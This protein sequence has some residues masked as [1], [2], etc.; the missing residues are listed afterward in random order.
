[1]AESNAIPVLAHF[2]FTG[3][4]LIAF[5]GVIGISVPCETDFKGGAPRT[6]LRL[7]ETSSAKDIEFKTESGNMSIKAGKSKFNVAVL[8]FEDFA[9]QMD[10]IPKLPKELYDIDADKFIEALGMCLRSVGNNN[11]RADMMGVTIIR[12]KGDLFFFSYDRVSVSQASMRG[13]IDAK[14]IIVPAE[15]CK[16]AIAL[17]GKDGEFDVD[18][19]EDACLIAANGVKLWAAPLAPDDVPQKFF[20]IVDSQM[21]KAG[22]KLRIEIPDN[23]SEI[24]ERAKIIG[25]SGVA[26]TKTKVK[27]KDGVMT[28]DSRN[29]AGDVFDSMPC[30]KHPEVSVAIDASVVQGG[31][32]LDEICF[33]DSAVVMA[34]DRGRL[35]YLVS[36]IGE[37]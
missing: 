28:F 34:K 23:L 14:R 31:C 29:D 11:V 37:D 6:M 26:K 16:Q 30:G 25:N 20:E 33:T 32:D 12:D 13:D 36:L 17:F 18:L 4:T 19:T 22:P 35:L 2:W 5:N 21:E 10:A 7:L 9:D 8:P 1:L 3:K 24:L 15:W 27:V